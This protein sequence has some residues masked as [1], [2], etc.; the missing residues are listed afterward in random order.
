MTLI[1]KLIINVALLLR[2][3]NTFN[4]SNLLVSSRENKSFGS[5]APRKDLIHRTFGG[6]NCNWG[7]LRKSKKA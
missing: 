3:A 6:K 7:N 5:F 4:S 2:Y 1:Q